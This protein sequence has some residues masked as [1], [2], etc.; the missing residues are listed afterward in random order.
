MQQVQD[1]LDFQIDTLSDSRLERMH[2]HP[3]PNRLQRRAKEAEERRAE[4]REN[5]AKSRER[6]SKPDL[7]EII[8]D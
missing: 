7:A 6:K 1:Q 3:E 4:R 2:A 5:R 8:Y